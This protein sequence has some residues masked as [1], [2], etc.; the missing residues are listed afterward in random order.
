MQKVTEE[1]T[2]RRAKIEGFNISA[3]TGT[4]QAYDRDT[5][6]YS[7]TDFLGSIL[8]IFP[9]EDP[10]II[11]YIVIDRP[12]GDYTYG[13]RIGSPMVKELA[14]ELIPILGL[15]LSNSKKFIHTGNIRLRRDKLEALNGEMPDLTGSDK[16]SVLNFIKEYNL[17]SNLNGDGWVVYQFPPAGTEITKNMTVYLEMK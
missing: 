16:R 4:A 5:G 1:G 7:T 9:T 8:A 17:Q 10:E 15:N 6:L 3:K 14:E 12:M 11:V 2:A 13:G